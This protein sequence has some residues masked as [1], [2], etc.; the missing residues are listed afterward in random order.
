MKFLKISLLFVVLLIVN[1]NA[2]VYRSPAY[3]RFIANGYINQSPY[4]NTLEA[5][6]NDV[7]DKATVENP[8]VFWVAGDS[9]RIPDWDSVFTSSGLTMKDSIDLYYVALGTIKWAGFGFGGSGGGSALI[10][11]QDDTTYHYGWDN[12]NVDNLALPYWQR[13]LGKS[14]DDVDEEVW[15][16]IVYTKDPLYIENDTLKI[17]V[18]G[19]SGGGIINFDSLTYVRTTGDQTISGIKTF[20]GTNRITGTLDFA[21]SGSLQLSGTNSGGISQ[22]RRLWGVGD[23]IYYSGTGTDTN[24]VAQIDEVDKKLDCDTCI[25]ISNLS[26][27]VIALINQEPPHLF[28]DKDTYTPNVTE[29]IYLKLT[30]TFNEIE[31]DDITVD[32]D[33]ITILANYE[34]HFLIQVVFTIQNAATDDFT[35]QIRKNNVSDHSV[36]FTGAGGTAYLAV[37][38]MHYFVGLVAGDDISFYITNTANN[39]DPVMTEINVFMYRIHP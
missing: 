30:P 16:L 4:F 27:E 22:P 7:K 10:I 3:V 1:I 12:W 29:D 11:Q 6:L 14:F 28:L 21:G 17:D 20:S 26:D 34:G 33:S 35:L 32:G 36:R 8:Y 2:Q 24:Q 23:R 31:A 15:R 19:F 18:S 5:A 9:I 13:L 39:N 25:Q 38:T 37:S